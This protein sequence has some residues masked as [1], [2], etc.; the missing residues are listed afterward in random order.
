MHVTSTGRRS[1]AKAL[2]AGVS[3]VLAA[4]S[5]PAASS[6]PGSSTDPGGDCDGYPSE[7]V[8]FV[9]PYGPGGGFDTWARL[10]APALQDALGVTVVPV[11]REGAGGLVGVTEVLSAEPDGY[12]VVIT[13][14]GVLATQQIAG[15]TD[16]DFSSLQA[17]GRLTVG[18]EVIVVAADSEWES[19]EDVQGDA[20]EA[21]PFLMASG[22]IAAIN[23]VAFEELGLPYT[24]VPHDSSP[25]ALL[26][27]VRGDTDIAVYP[28]TSVAEGISGGDLRPLVLV[29]EPPAAGQPGADLVEGVPT[30]DEVTGTAGI[31]AALAQTRL[32]AAPPGTPDCVIAALDQALADVFAGEEFLGQLDEAGFI[33][34]HGSA[35]Q[36]QEVIDIT[37]TTLEGYAD[38]LIENLGE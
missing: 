29:G 3:L 27:L 17:I 8:E 30:L 26:S 22:G 33:P 19:I 5:S 25:D 9:I 14:P 10:V 13:E 6:D 28:L 35:A 16:A 38:L 18:P 11:N 37:F 31:G 1:G 4:C 23:I 7:D 34:V 24:D 36:A 21:D 15:T 12:T 32:V 20:D 2:L